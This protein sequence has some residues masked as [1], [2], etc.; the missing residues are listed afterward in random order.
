MRFHIRLRGSVAGRLSVQVIDV[1]FERLTDVSV[2]SLL[3]CI[4]AYVLWD[5][6]AKARPSYIGEG[7]ILKRL[8]EH[9]YRLDY[10]LDGY[11]APVFESSRQRAK[12]HAEIVEALLLVVAHQTD[13]KPSVNIASGKLR[14]IDA[15]FRS[16]GTIRINVRGFDPLTPPRNARPL[17]ATKQIVLKDLPDGSLTLEHSWNARRKLQ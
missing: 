8:T 2:A 16:H 13:R 9:V 7:V 15:I 17:S 3:G 14:A 1:T 10:P 5:S 12:A 6:K 11:A 4:G